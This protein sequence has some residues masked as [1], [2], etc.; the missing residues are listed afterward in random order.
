MWHSWVAAAPALELLTFVG[1]DTL[2]A[3]TVGL[4]E[5]FRSAVGLPAGE[6]PIV[7]AVAD[8]QVPALMEEAAIIG[9]VRAGRLR[10]SFHVSTGQADADRAADVLSGHLRYAGPG[11]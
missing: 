11:K 8:E 6:S 2:H 1:T 9:S 7:S 4:A 10:L 3:H 5:R